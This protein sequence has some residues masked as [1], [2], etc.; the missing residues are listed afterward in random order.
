MPRLA[1]RNFLPLA[2]FPLFL[3]ASAQAATFLF[4]FEDQP[5]GGLTEN[6]FTTRTIV[7]DSLSATFTRS[8]GQG[9]SFTD[10]A[11]VLTSQGPVPCSDS[12][13]AA[14]CQPA[15]WGIRSLSPFFNSSVPDYFIVDLNQA[16]SSIGIQTGDRNIDQ[17]IVKLEL[18]DGPLGTGNL[19][20]SVSAEYLIP[21]AIP[22]NIIS[23]SLDGNLIRSIRLYG[24]SSPDPNSMFW[25]NL[26]IETTDTPPAPVPAPLP[27]LGAGIAFGYSRRL[28]QRI[29]RA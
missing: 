5:S 19:L 9:F 6:Q 22:N 16:V 3:G 15:S 13:G 8:S 1:L 20:G 26:T 17:D 21:D 23:L 7:K 18:F 24:G 10:L 14:G 4:D 27:V 25:D 12:F 29:R 11:T 28:R 2:F